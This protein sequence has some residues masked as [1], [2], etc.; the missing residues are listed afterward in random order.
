M[1]FLHN[2]LVL[3]ALAALYYQ[4]VQGDSAIQA[5]IKIL[6]F[7]IAMVIS[8]VGSG[9]LVTAIGYYNHIILFETAL[10]TAG[11]AL[12][13][14]FWLDTPL[15]KWFPAQVVMG[16][17]TGICFQAP[18]IAVQNVLPPHLIPQATACTQ[19]FQALGGSVFIAVGQTVFQNGL[20]SNLVRD[21]PG[22]DPAAIIN[23]GASQ[24]RQLVQQMG[25]GDAVDSVLGAY[26][27]GLRNSYYI[28]VATAACAFLVTWGL[29]WKRIQKPDVKKDE[30]VPDAAG[31]TDTDAT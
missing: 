6:P 10:L 12:I 25:R 23:S 5:G 7:L 13:A 24:I 15:S 2:A 31:Q 21:A 26:V 28:S 27:L 11:A 20:V 14:T 17:G 16:L 3:T 29:E 8:S 18:I 19:F 4:A 1:S 22:I 30:E 9:V